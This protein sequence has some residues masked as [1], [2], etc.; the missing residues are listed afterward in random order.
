MLKLTDNGT[1]HPSEAESARTRP[2]RRQLKIRRDGGAEF[3]ILFASQKSAK[4]ETIEVG[5]S[6]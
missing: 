1:E 4:A 2:A 5:A 3:R 6:L